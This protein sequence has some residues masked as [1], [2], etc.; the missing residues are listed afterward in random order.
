MWS[1]YSKE[2]EYSQDCFCEGVSIDDIN[3]DRPFRR[4]EVRE[5]DWYGRILRYSGLKKE[6]LKTLEARLEERLVT[7]YENYKNKALRF[8][9]T[10]KKLKE[11]FPDIL[12]VCGEGVSYPPSKELVWE[13]YS[14]KYWELVKEIVERYAESGMWGTVVRTCMGPEDH[15]WNSA[16]DKIQ[17]INRAFLGVQKKY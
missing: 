14:E 11:N 4:K 16:K 7:D 13:E 10:L 9:E 2:E 5:N 8:K 3:A 15:S 6:M 12:V 1:I 17:S